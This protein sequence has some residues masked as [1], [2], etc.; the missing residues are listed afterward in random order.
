[1]AFG[2]PSLLGL[3]LGWGAAARGGLLPLQDLLQGPEAFVL[4]TLFCFFFRI[5]V[6][7]SSASFEVT[8]LAVEIPGLSLSL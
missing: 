2:C 6:C 1:M 4:D 5:S 7:A 8:G 3:E